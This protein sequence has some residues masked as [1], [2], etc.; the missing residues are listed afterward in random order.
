MSTNDR[1]PRLSRGKSSPLFERRIDPGV[2]TP[3]PER[4]DPPSRLSNPIPRGVDHT[5]PERRMPVK[6]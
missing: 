1:E 6:R 5:G 3:R 4:V 2:N